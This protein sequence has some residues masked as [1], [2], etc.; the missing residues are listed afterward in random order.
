M[1][2]DTIKITAVDLFESSIEASK[3]RNIYDYYIKGDVNKLN[4]YVSQNSFDCV[5]AFDLIEHLS[6]V[7]GIKLIQNM[8]LVARNK[9]I[10]FTPNGF[11]FQPA[12][13]D[14]PF[15]EHIS[16]WTYDEMKNLGFKIHGV[17]GYKKLRA[18]FAQPTI[19]P[20]FLGG[21]LSNLSILVLK[22]FK[23]ED[24]SFSILC[25]KEF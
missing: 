7:D 16:G 8:S 22:I 1:I 19:K 15:Q 6:K 2:N 10:I 21:F 4:E 17:F 13:G 9:I 14:N 5:V 3:K 20:N 18:E 24:L 25:I 23:R 12:H 11:L